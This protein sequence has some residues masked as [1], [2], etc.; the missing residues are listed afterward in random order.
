MAKYYKTQQPNIYAQI[1]AMKL[2]YPQFR[3]S[4]KGLSI[5]F[6]GQLMIKPELPIYKVSIEYRGHIRPLVHVI[7]PALVENAPHTYHDKS[8]CLFHP[9]NFNWNAYKI[10]A[11]EIMQW[12]IAW[13]YFY[14]YWLQSGDWIGP[15][16][17]HITEKTNE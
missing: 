17:P 16:V 4:V 1:S 7:S 14:E 9:S 5:K 2:K 13:I 8:L 11:N 3:S 15:E 6:I 12:T 10:I